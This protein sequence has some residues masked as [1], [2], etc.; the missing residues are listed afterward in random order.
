[1]PPCLPTLVR[2][3]FA[4]DPA[5]ELVGTRYVQRNGGFLHPLSIPVVPEDVPGL[6]FILGVEDEGGRRDQGP[7]V[8]III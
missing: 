7:W 2:R 6:P 5:A 1:M 8:T 4:T 3:P